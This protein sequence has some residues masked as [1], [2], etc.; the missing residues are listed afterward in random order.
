MLCKHLQISRRPRLEKAVGEY[1]ETGDEKYRESHRRQPTCRQTPR[2]DIAVPAGA[3]RRVQRP[4]IKNA[5]ATE[6]GQCHCPRVET[7]FMITFYRLGGHAPRRSY[8]EGRKAQ[9]AGWCWRPGHI[10]K[11][12]AAQT[13]VPQ[14]SPD[15]EKAF[16]VTKAWA[17]KLLLDSSGTALPCRCCLQYSCSLSAI[18]SR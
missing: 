10:R 17:V 3:A 13:S 16:A 14:R 8:F 1:E 15:F 12:N 2:Q 6:G 18:Y 7:E 11:R 4:Q 9:Y 5:V